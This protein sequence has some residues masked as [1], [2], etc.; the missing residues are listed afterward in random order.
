MRREYLLGHELDSATGYPVRDAIIQYVTGKCDAARFVSSVRQLT[1]NYPPEQMRFNLSIL[2]SHD[3]LRII[4]ALGDAPDESSMSQEAKE[5]YSLPAHKL[6]L[7]EEAHAYEPSAVHS[8][9]HGL[10]RRR[11][12][13]ARLFGPPAGPLPVG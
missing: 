4:T 7:R 3:V 2:G 12:R 8:Q 13:N 10:L 11:S 6:T 1:E 9:H 5:A